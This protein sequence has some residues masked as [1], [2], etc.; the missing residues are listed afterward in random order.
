[1]DNRILGIGRVLLAI[2]M[3][4]KKRKGKLMKR[5]LTFFLIN[6][7]K[8]R[9]KKKKNIHLSPY[10]IKLVSHKILI[11]ILIAKRRKGGG[12]KRRLNPFEIVFLINP[13][14]RG[15]GEKKKNNSRR[16]PCCV[17]SSNARERQTR[18]IARRFTA[19]TR[20]QYNF[21]NRREIIFCTT[22]ERT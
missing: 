1:M 10:N 9:K 11:E 6:N 3:A 19:M 4:V 18:K 16:H 5:K 21:S 12:S 7:K 8:K 17:K 22:Y 13:S 20:I 15:E 14:C 2:P